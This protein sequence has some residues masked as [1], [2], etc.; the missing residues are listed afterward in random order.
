MNRL[1]LFVLAAAAAAL[2]AA[3]V[4]RRDLQFAIESDDPAFAY[5]IATPIGTFT[6]EDAFRRDVILRPGVRWAWS[7]P[8]SPVAP[9]LGLDLLHEEAPMQDGDGLR[10]NGV[11]ATAGATWSPSSAIAIDA[12]AHAAWSQAS[13]ALDTADGTGL[14]GDGSQTALGARLR[15]LWTPTPRWSL[16]IEAGWAQ[17]S[18]SISADRSRQVDLDAAG[19]TAGLVL[20]WRPSARP[21]GLE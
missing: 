14:S 13:L 16:G 7:R 3:E 5:R 11:G 2:P 12:E 20:A 17:R 15:A 4:A 1:S 21:A 9:L 6:G 18:L 19:W 8:G 10:A